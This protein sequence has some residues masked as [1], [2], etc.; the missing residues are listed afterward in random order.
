LVTKIY[1]IAA[2]DTVAL[3][4]SELKRVLERME[5]GSE[6]AICAMRTKT[7]QKGYWLGLCDALGEDQPTVKDPALDDGYCIRTQ[8]AAGIIAG[9]NERSVLLAVYR[10]LRELGCAWVRPG[11]MG[12][13]I[14]N[15]TVVD[16]EV[17]VCEAAS[18][19][20]RGVCIEGAVNYDH[21]AEMI[22][23]LPKIGMNGYFNQFW[24]PFSF[25][26]TWYKHENNPLIQPNPVTRAEVDGFVLDQLQYIRREGLMYHAAG[27]GW[28]C[29]PFGLDSAG[30]YKYYD[31]LPEGMQELLAML[32]G[33]RALYDDLPLNT[34]LCYANPVVK[35][36]MVS[37]I[38]NYCLEHPDVDYLHFWL[39]DAMNNQCECPACRD[40]RPADHYVDILN[41]LDERLT[42]A[43]VTARIVFLIYFDLMWTPQESKITNPDRFVLMFAPISRTYS[44]SYADAEIKDTDKVLPFEY[45]KLKLPR[46]VGEN[47]AFLREWQKVFQGDSFI[48]DYHLWRDY[49]LDAGFA[50]ISGVLFKDMRYLHQLG[51][52]GMMSCQSQRV[53]YPSPLPMLLMAD[54][55]WDHQADYEQCVCKHYQNAYGELGSMVRLYLERLSQLMDSSYLRNE[56]PIISEI[57]YRNFTRAEEHIRSCLPLFEQKLKDDP[58]LSGAIRRSLEILVNHASLC[59]LLIRALTLRASGDEENVEAAWNDTVA[60]A[61][62]QELD[63][64]EVF[65]VSMFQSSV[66]DFIRNR[67]LFNTA[68]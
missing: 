15:I 19:R 51:I 57:S 24:T 47:V 14:P 28:T 49:A 67:K 61:R 2:G 23:W 36:K 46:S 26:D 1:Y 31:A 53:F 18:Y 54:A 27:H 50:Q 8:G 32:N 9:V 16:Q 22:K 64:H 17:N 37:A 68:D 65:D 38:T 25:Y 7:N 20:H 66:G 5:S 44:S 39:A 30:W 35:D 58:K 10:Y 40:K 63:F 60:Y 29:A 48:Y 45:N 52:N 33:K 56:K 59:L 34:N 12:E 43:G 6:I 62:E 42:E 4:A 41:L 3:A 55:L 21:V 13:I 11:D